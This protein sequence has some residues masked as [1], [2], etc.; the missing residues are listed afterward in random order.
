MI[1]DEKHKAYQIED[2]I[3]HCGTSITMHYI[4][5]KW[6]CIVL[7]YLRNGKMRFSELKKLIPDITEKMLS[8]QL[9]SLQKDGLVNRKV[10]GIK[11]PLRTEYSLSKFGETI[12]PVVEIITIWGIKIGETKGDLID[13]D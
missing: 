12:I 1:L 5:G 11:P 10:Y 4:G 7:W 13:V 9:K 8:L 6:K 3:Y 2:K